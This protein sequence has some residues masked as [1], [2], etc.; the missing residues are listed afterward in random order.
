MCGRVEFWK[1]GAHG[2]DVPF[3]QSREKRNTPSMRPCRC[4]GGIVIQLCLVGSPF[5]ETF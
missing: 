2:T 3:V 5:F 1:T 4:A